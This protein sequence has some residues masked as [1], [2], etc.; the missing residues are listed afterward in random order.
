MDAAVSNGDAGDAATLTLLQERL[1]RLEFLLH[2]RTDA[3]GISFAAKTPSNVD[4]AVVARLEKMRTA[5]QRLT[6]QQGAVR[7]I[8]DLGVCF[9][10]LY[11]C[12]LSLRHLRIFLSF[13]PTIQVPHFGL[14][15][16]Q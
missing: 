6:A 16:W 15:F 9:S 3:F 11:S 7:D 12:F 4:G 2:G 5:L 1:H 8:L 13:I 10:F 14:D